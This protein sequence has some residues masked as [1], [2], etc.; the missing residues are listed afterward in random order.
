MNNLELKCFFQQKGTLRNDTSC[1]I[2]RPK[3]RHL[4]LGEEITSD[5]YI[6]FNS[7]EF[8]RCYGVKCISW[9]QTHDP[10]HFTTRPFETIVGT[11]HI[12][13]KYRGN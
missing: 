11:L 3:K 5:Y 8:S 6:Y 7:T 2:I 4:R 9:L 13:C 10:N 12:S 1:H